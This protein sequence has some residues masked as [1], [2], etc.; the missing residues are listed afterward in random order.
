MGQL[1]EALRLEIKKRALNFVGNRGQ[2]T[3]PILFLGEAPG[4][5][6]DR[7]GYPFVGP[8]G[9]ELDRE[10]AEAGISQHDCW[11]TNP[12]PVRPPDNKMP[13]LPELGIP[14]V[15]YEKAFWE[16]MW[17]TKPSL[18][19]TCGKTPTNLLCPET[20]I[21]RKGK[22]DE[23]GISFSHWRGSLL[24]SPHLNWPHYVIPI[25]HPAFILRD[26]SEKSNNVFVLRRVLE[27]FQY[28]R[29]NGKLNPLPNRELIV[30]PNASAAIEFL[31]ELLHAGKPT[32]CDIEMLRRK[33]PYTI[34]FSNNTNRAMSLCFWDYSGRDATR[35]WRYL[36]VVLRKVP[37]IGQNFTT[38]DASW[39]RV[40][41]LEPNLSLVD[42]T[43]IRHHVLWP[44][45]SH[46]LEYQVM[47]YTREPFFKEEGKG[48]QASEG[49]SKLMRYNCKDAATT[50]EIY[51]EQETEFD[52][53]PSLR[54]FYRDYEMPLARAY[55]EIDKRGLLVDIPTR[56]KVRTYIHGEA[57]KVLG[58]IVTVSGKRCF[59]SLEQ[60][61]NLGVKREPSDVLLSS[62]KDILQ[63]LRDCGIKPKKKPFT[64]VETTDEESLNELFAETNHPV[65]KLILRTR[66]L[67]KIEGTYIDQK[68]YQNI[69]Y[70]NYN[71]AGTV[72]GRR[73]ARKS[74]LHMGSNHQNQPKHSDLG[75]EL[76][77]MY[78]ARP[79]KVFV[80]CDQ[81]QAED[82]IVSGL[83][84]DNSN[85][86]TGLDELLRGVDR[87][88]KLAAFIF[89]MPESMCGK[90]TIQRFLGKKVRHAG[91]YD[92]GANRMAGALAKEG[93]SI[94]PWECEALLEKFHGATPEIRG[95]FH[96]WV[97]N[98]LTRNRKLRTP[99][100]RERVFFGLH[101][102]RDNSKLFKE[103]YS[104]V[105]QSSVGDNTGLAVLYCERKSRGLVIH[106]CHDS[107]GLEVD[108]NFESVLNAMELLTEAF[109]RTITFDNGLALEIPIEYEIG[110]DFRSVTKCASASRDGLKNIW[111]TL[112]LHPRARKTFISG[113]LLP[114]SAQSSN[115][116]FG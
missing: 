87:H 1:Q 73:S 45:L 77:E 109:H 86:R 72:G 69:S 18:I 114:Q 89:G 105:P 10:I 49:K 93:Y 92:M 15:D 47:Q 48:W 65:L 70:T 55:Y 57:K 6:E 82:W 24:R 21:V 40:I 60:I 76:R 39:L 16:K 110:F 53:N 43:L 96:Q 25:Y 98:C 116:V 94:K 91:N 61:E 99:F 14:A 27:E 104:Y 33:I 44:E 8:S 28:L 37:I 113:V 7:Q 52:D 112:D 68:L 11:F 30:E 35:I 62:P 88:T 81:I 103:A 41:G 50:L 97:I 38:F 111:P 32:G 71:V 80:F 67:D 107:I 106:E 3:S 108:Y 58:E 75:K 29:A 90:D 20:V 101:P 115:E 17:E 63:L 100:E 85:S 51:Q 4:E 42:D 102:F 64:N 34:S 95:V 78:V 74:F 31:R 56:E 23:E 66:E 36:S 22:S 5:E 84:A 13:R 54:R 2:S 83:I 26:Y 9:K 79:G 59:S 12:Y 46:K 19:V